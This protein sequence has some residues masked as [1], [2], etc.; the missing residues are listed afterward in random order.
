MINPLLHNEIEWKLFNDELN[1]MADKTHVFKASLSS[2]SHLIQEDS[3]SVL[4]IQ[5]LK[6]SKRFIKKLDGERYAIG[7]YLLRIILS[8]FTGISPASLKF[9]TIANKKPA[10]EGIEFNVS[11]SGNLIVIAIGPQMIG[12]DVEFINK[13]F[14]Y[15]LILPNC[16]NQNEQTFI[17]NYDNRLLNFYTLWTRKEAILKASGEGLADDLCDL[18]SLSNYT[19]RK[20]NVF[21][22]SSHIIDNEY[23]MSL[24]MNDN[25]NVNYWHLKN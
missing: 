9:N 16:F 2:F 7:K 4:S 14:D 12:A 5:E 3:K 6:K 21:D 17:H 20:N 13:N 19:T 18:D 1:L 8:Y 25:S 22:I 11:H 23:I 24:A 15:E 10:I